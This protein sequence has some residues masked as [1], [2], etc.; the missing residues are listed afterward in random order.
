MINNENE[1]W[2]GT[3]R[4]RNVFQ[5]IESLKSHSFSE[6]FYS[7]NKQHPNDFILFDFQVV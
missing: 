7:E 5:L 6:N 4:S 2:H 1:R 3:C